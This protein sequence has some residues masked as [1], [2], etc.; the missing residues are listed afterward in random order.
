M[1]SPKTISGQSQNYFG[2]IGAE[3]V[4]LFRI[5]I[6]TEYRDYSSPSVSAPMLPMIEKTEVGVSKFESSRRGPKDITQLVGEVIGDLA[7]RLG[8]G[9]DDG[10]KT[11]EKSRGS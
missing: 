11:V 2:T 8:D 6:D 9:A 10:M 5:S 1:N 4:P 7:R 3:I